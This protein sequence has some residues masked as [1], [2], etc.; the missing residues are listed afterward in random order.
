MF[1]IQPHNLEAVSKLKMMEKMDNMGITWKL[2]T[3]IP[4]TKVHSLK[5]ILSDSFKLPG[6]AMLLEFNSWQNLSNKK[7][8][9]KTG[10][11]FDGIRMEFMVTNWN[12]VDG[13][14]FY[15]GTYFF[16]NPC[17]SIIV[18]LV[19]GFYGQ[20]GKLYKWMSGFELGVCFLLPFSIVFKTR[21]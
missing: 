1:E 4:K 8:N 16:S 15:C 3:K 5:S 19:E 12:Y 14:P 17:Y 2:F 9:D 10:V 6:V 7:D 18:E 20:R 11:V 21:V 13:V